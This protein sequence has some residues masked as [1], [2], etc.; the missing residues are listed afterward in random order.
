MDVDDIHSL[1][2]DATPTGPAAELAQ[3]LHTIRERVSDPEVCQM[4]ESVLTEMARQ[5]AEKDR[6]LQERLPAAG[7]VKAE[8][9]LRALCHYV[10]SQAFR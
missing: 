8:A 6:Q 10:A 9:A 5:I 1:I 7:N 4:I 3:F 2:A